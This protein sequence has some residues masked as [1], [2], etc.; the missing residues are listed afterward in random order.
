M[1]LNKV[2]KVNSDSELLSFIINSNPILQSNI[3]LPVQGESIA[4][5][6][7]LIMSNQ[8]FKNAFINAVNQI[9]LTIIDRNYWE[10]PWE[11]FI[12]RGVLKIGSSVREMAV[13]IAP[14]FDYNEFCNDPT[15]FLKNV[16]PEV[17]QYIHELNYQKFYKVTTSDEQIAM[18]FTQ[19]NGLFSL[20]ETIVGS[21][22]EGYKYDTYIV[23]KYMLCRRILDGTITSVEIKNYSSIGTREIVSFIKNVS[24]LLTFM[25]PN[26]NPAGLR[27]STSFDRQIAILNTAFSADLDTSVIATSFFR[28]AAEMKT[29][30]ALIDDFGKHDIVRLIQLLGDAYI[31]FTETELDSLKSIPAGIFDEEWFQNYDYALDSNSADINNYDLVDDLTQRYNQTRITSY[32]NPE[33]LRNNHW[34]HTWKVV[35]SSPYKQAVVFTAG[36][37]PAVDSITL[38]P[39]EC[40]VSAGLTVQLTANVQTTGFANKSVVYSVDEAPG[41]SSTNKVTVNPVTGLVTIPSDYKPTSTES[42][43]PIVIKATSVF[44]PS[45]TNTATISVV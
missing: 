21:L 4:P 1:A 36:V 27:R 40:T 16:V 11:N 10:N 19:P 17:Y 9:G 37:T 25:S 45:I 6:G 43:N 41:E 29:R 20:I 3:D 39:A 35:S 28:D 33:S 15:H 42:A 22:Y 24:N 5:I 12:N 8:N 18:A 31:P 26:Y 34:L 30:M 7:Q 38:S 32:Y 2:L 14:V 13:D 44:N 23:N